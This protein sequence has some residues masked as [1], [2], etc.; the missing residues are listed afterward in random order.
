MWMGARAARAVKNA[1][2]PAVL[3]NGRKK[4]KKRNGGETW[5]K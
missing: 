2:A 3:V 1:S 4:K 5:V